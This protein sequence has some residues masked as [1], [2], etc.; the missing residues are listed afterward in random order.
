MPCAPCHSLPSA[1]VERS[2]IHE[3]SYIL[4]A[5]QHRQHLAGS[6]VHPWGMETLLT[7]PVHG[8]ILSHHHDADAAML[9]AS[10][11][12]S[13]TAI[14]SN[15]FPGTLLICFP[16]PA[17]VLVLCKFGI[18]TLSAAAGV[19]SAVNAKHANALSWTIP[20][21]SQVAEHSIECPI[22]HSSEHAPKLFLSP[23][24]PT[25]EPHASGRQA[26]YTQERL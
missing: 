21:L 11:Q 24:N 15:T 12:S 25:T 14:C 5:S 19:M 22:N 20:Y 2:Q 16:T 10:Y 3:A 7:P 8:T 18:C 4:H 17:S 1:P 23:L 26:R 9:T 13:Q 6:C